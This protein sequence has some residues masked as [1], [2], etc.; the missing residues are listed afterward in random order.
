MTLGHF[1]TL[2]KQAAPALTEALADPDAGVQAAAADALGR[3]GPDATAA[4]PE[5]L[6][7]VKSPDATVRRAAVFALGRVE[8]ADKPPVAVALIALLKA[9]EDDATRREVITSLGLL[10]ESGGE[11]VPTL[12]TQLLNPSAEFRLLTLDALGRL[13]PAVRG[14][15]PQL[16]TLVQKDPDGAVRRVSARTLVKGLGDD[17]KRLVPLLA[18][19]LATDAEFEVRVAMAQE[20]GGLGALAVAAI[21]A[22]RAAQRDPQIRVR[23]AAIAAVKQIERD[24]RK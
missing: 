11:V 18:E 5:L 6:K 10:G 24:R 13:G 17:A 16:V 23:E 14:A 9:T 15:E 7:L 8:P 19:R 3:V 12:A 1:G 20:L 4:T 2:A 21:P 22:L